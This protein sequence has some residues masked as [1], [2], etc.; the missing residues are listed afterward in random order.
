L[1]LEN[2]IELYWD[3]KISLVSDK[4][5]DILPAGHEFLRASPVSLAQYLLEGIIC[6]TNAGYKHE[7]Y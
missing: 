4:G 2:F 3:V 7:T 6:R 1:I 5:T